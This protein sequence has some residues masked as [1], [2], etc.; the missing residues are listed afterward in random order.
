MQHDDPNAPRIDTQLLEDTDD[1]QAE[2]SNPATPAISS[3]GA[4]EPRSALRRSS[5]RVATF[6]KQA[7]AMTREHSAK[8]TRQVAEQGAP[9]VQSAATR[10]GAFGSHARDSIRTRLVPTDDIEAFERNATPLIDP[11]ATEAPLPVTAVTGVALAAASVGAFANAADLMRFTRPLMDADAAGLQ[12]WL[13]EVFPAAVNPAVSRAMDTLPGA[14]YAGGMFHRLHHGHDVA[15]LVELVRAFGFDG[16]ASWFNHVGL[17]DLW[18]PHGVPWLPAGAGDVHAWLV[19]LG[20][21][22][23]LAATL[24]SVNAATLA[25]SALGLLAMTA[26]RRAVRSSIER[27]E[28][29]R[30]F[31][32]ALAALD[33]GDPV[34]ATQRFEAAMRLPGMTARLRLVAAMS[35]LEAARRS[36]DEQTRRRVAKDA[37]YWLREFLADDGGETA[38]QASAPMWAGADVSTPGIAAVLYGQAIMLAYDG[39]ATGTLEIDR[40]RTGVAAAT[41]HGDRLLD[42]PK[43]G[44]LARPARPLSAAV[45]YVIALETVLAYP[46]RLVTGHAEPEG[47]RRRVREALLSAAGTEREAYARRALER[48][49]HRYPERAL[50]LT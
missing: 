16:A 44:P 49:E 48:L 31:D 24:L 37:S 17:R 9:I 41:E 25:G 38:R 2:G 26:F 3:D 20:M 12:S 21:Q 5:R 39:D 14:D 29:R 1:V 40:M 33:A 19:D 46:S 43:L 23:T 13:A 4:T 6:L 45:N 42:P 10:V 35:A 11:A 18:T 50:A 7:G 8:A 28:A 15:G 22:K 32:H 27:A 47:L 30:R 34:T 36:D